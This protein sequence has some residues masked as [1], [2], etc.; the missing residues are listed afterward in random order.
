[1]RIFDCPVESIIAKHPDLYLEHCA[2]MAVAQ[3][4]GQSQSPA[5]LVVDCEGFA[6]NAMQS[7]SSFL[8]RVAWD[9]QPEKKAN[10]LRLTEQSTPIIER[11]AVAMA[12]LLFGHFVPNGAMRVT[13]QGDRA[14]YWLPG[15]RCAL[16]ISGT[17]ALRRFG[18]RCKQKS[19]QMLANPRVWNGYVV[20]C[21]FSKSR[22]IIRWSYH[23][24]QE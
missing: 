9:P 13:M 10:R 6:P 21:G 17:A 12:A 16:E 24:Q 11:A 1:M 14:D 2:V 15:L 5:E 23:E 4:S 20:T 3:L 8:L 7:E 18:A 19:A 22:N